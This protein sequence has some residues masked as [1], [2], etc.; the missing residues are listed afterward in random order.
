MIVNIFVG[1][2]AYTHRVPCGQGTLRVSGDESRT[3]EYCLFL[4]TKPNNQNAANR[5]ISGCNTVL[6]FN[7]AF[8]ALNPTNGYHFRLTQIASFRFTTFAMTTGPTAIASDRGARSDIRLS[9]ELSGFR[10]AALNSGSIA[11]IS[12]GSHNE[13]R[14]TGV[15]NHA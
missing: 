2:V 14:S 7:N 10:L 6:F 15:Y 13:N 9:A 3:T 1:W 4:A 8:L 5:W 12:W 11:S